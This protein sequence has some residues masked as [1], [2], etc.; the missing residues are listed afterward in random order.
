MSQGVFLH[1]LNTGGKLYD[2]T[3]GGGFIANNKITT[4]SRVKALAFAQANLFSE[5]ASLGASDQNTAR[6]NLGLAIGTNVQAYD[7]QLDT[8]AALSAAAVNNLTD[9]AALS[10]TDGGF[11]VSDGSDFTVE[12]AATARASLGLTIGTHV[13]AYDA[14]LDDIS[15]LTPGDGK[16]IVCLLYTSDAADE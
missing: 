6:S 5:V 1:N 13:Q 14:Q 12:S 9:I 16:F 4:E 2:T 11:I 7:A 10:H 3:A 8:L 15:G